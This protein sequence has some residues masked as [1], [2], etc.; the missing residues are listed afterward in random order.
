M[1]KE[2]IFQEMTPS[3]DE[4]ESLRKTK[5]KV[6]K[7]ETRVEVSLCYIMHYSF[8]AGMYKRNTIISL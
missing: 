5:F 2:S 8:D 4:V 3:K 7:I 1:S 6:D